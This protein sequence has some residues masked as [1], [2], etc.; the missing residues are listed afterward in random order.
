MPTFMTPTELEEAGF[1]L[2]R[3]HQPIIDFSELR[4]RKESSEQY[5]ARSL[6]VTQCILRLTAH[7]G[8]TPFFFLF[9]PP[10]SISFFL[11]INELIDWCISFWD[12][13]IWVTGTRGDVK[14]Y[15]IIF[16]S[17]SF[18]ASFG[19]SRDSLVGSA[20]TQDSWNSLGMLDELEFPPLIN[21]LV[22]GA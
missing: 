15:L 14:V 12:L 10:P 20:L 13:I 5:Y 9:F 7:I 6:Y 22:W 17:P 8:A 18:V 3:D 2:R 11:L 16:R 1:R 4:D 21:L 19:D